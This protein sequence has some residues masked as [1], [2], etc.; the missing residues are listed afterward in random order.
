MP[1]TIDI[2]EDGDSWEFE[3]SSWEEMAA[4]MDYLDDL[5]DI[6]Y[7]WSYDEG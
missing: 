5:T 3:V 6:D 4:W 1:F 7:F 2:S